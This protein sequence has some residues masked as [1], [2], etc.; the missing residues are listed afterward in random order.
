MI[1]QVSET[2]FIDAFRAIRP[3]N[4]TY[5]GLKALYVYLEDLEDGTDE[6]I[7][8]DVIGICCEYQEFKNWSEFEDDYGNTLDSLNFQVKKPCCDICI[9]Y[10]NEKRLEKLSERTTVI[11]V[12]EEFTAMDINGIMSSNKNGFIIQ[13]F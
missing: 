8:F 13:S 3:D 6:Q 10:W 7:Q 12:S 11:P 5:N 4:F 2:D 9:P 1:T